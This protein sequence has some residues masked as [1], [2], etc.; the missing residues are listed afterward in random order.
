MRKQLII[1]VI[2]LAF[3]A[4]AFAIGEARMTGKVID[5]ATKEPIANANIKYESTEKRKIEDTVAVKNDG[6]FALFLIDGTIRYKF[7]ISAPGYV[8]FEQTMKLDIGAN[9]FRNFELVKQSAATAPAAAAAAADPAVEAYN[10]GAL[11]ANNGDNAGARA[12]FEEAVAAKPGLTAGWIALAKVNLK[13]KDYPKAIEAANKVLEI[14][15]EDAVMWSILFDSYTALG[16]KQKAAEAK[17]KMPANPSVLF[18]DAARLINDG[19]DAQAEGLLKQ[20]VALDENMAVAWYQLGMLYTR[21]QKNAEAKAAFQK[22]L[23]V[24]PNG[25]EVETVKQLLAYLK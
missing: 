18:N 25:S 14:D 22:Y 21:A 5:A 23:E 1:G 17:A 13:L 2:L 11:L 3:A 4:S 8:P 9:N 10:E 15:N 24:D 7:T 16:D 20:A 19:K 6:T 12:K